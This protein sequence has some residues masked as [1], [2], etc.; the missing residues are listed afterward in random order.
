[1]GVVMMS[2]MLPVAVATAV[3]GS[4]VSG[5]RARASL[6]ATQVCGGLS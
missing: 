4:G 3:G 6:V 2:G 1:M 5:D